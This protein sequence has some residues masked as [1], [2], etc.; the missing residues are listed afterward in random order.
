M[1]S[2]GNVI[3]CGRLQVIVD[4]IEEL[5]T[6]FEEIMPPPDTEEE[7]LNFDPFDTVSM[8]AD[9]LLHDVIEEF[10]C[11]CGA[12]LV[13]YLYQFPCGAACA[14]RERR[15]KCKEKRAESS[16]IVLYIGHNLQWT[17]HG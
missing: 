11:V 1:A 8:I 4:E 5:A 12:G 2:T 14:Q 13:D 10:V 3:V 6:R 17:G 9:N 16:I 15:A 7:S